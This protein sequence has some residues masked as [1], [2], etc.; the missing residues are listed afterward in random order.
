MAT[1]T[2]DP[3]QLA[4]GVATGLSVV[5]GS[6]SLTIVDLGEEKILRVVNPTIA[7]GRV[8]FNMVDADANRADVDLYV[9]MRVPDGAF[10][11]VPM[12]RLGA[13]PVFYRGG[14]GSAGAV[15][16]HNIQKFVGSVTN[17]FGGS[18]ASF[19]ASPSPEP[20]DVLHVR[21]RMIGTNIRLKYWLNDTEEHPTDWNGG[22]G[23][24]NDGAIAAA[25]GVGFSFYQA[26]THDIEF[27]GIGTDGD[28][29][30]TGGE[31]G[32]GAVLAA[33]TVSFVSKSSTA[34]AMSCTA[35]TGGT[36]PYTYQWQRSPDGTTW[37]NVSGAT[38][39]A[40]TDSGLTPSTLYY[41][42]VVAT[43]AVA[44]TAATSALSVTTSSTVV[45]SVS[46]LF[47][48]EVGTPLSGADVFFIDTVSQTTQVATTDASGLAQIT[49]AVLGR[50]YLVVGRSGFLTTQARVQV[51]V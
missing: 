12:I 23:A 38:S 45:G 13:G 50:S 25:G 34:I 33:G 39:L 7:S 8:T 42:R 43:D 28:S 14:L 44:A 4:A 24:F 41:Y 18:N 19:P 37:T 5:T 40:L 11:L 47:V 31:V 10:D 21:L 46:A 16:W 22:G 27:V 9:R 6:P 48:T 26:L 15:V 2:Y 17:I 36:G 51:A 20:G 1:Y 32:G 49:N 35:A 29:A 3:N 30:P